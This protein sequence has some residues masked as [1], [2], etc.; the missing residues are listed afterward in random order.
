M[1]VCIY[2]QNLALNDLQRL[3][4]H[5]TQ[6]TTIYILTISTYQDIAK[7]STYLCISRSMIICV[8]ELSCFFHVRTFRI[9]LMAALILVGDTSCKGIT[10]MSKCYY[11][12]I[13]LK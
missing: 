9:P 1:Y 6:T 2:R 11:I 7:L 4:C 10:V 13:D 8:G 5:K 12:I 3:I